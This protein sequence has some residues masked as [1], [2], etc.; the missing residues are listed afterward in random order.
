MQGLKRIIYILDRIA[1]FSRWTNV[2]GVAALFLMVSSTFIDVIMRYFFNSPIR[3]VGEGVGIMMIIAVFF[4]VAHTQNMRA[5]V[6]VDVITSLLAPKTLLMVEFITSIL[7]LVIFAV[8]IWQC[9]VEISWVLENNVIHTQSV[10]ISKAPFLIVI[11]LGCISL[12]LILLRDILAR[13]NEAMELGIGRR[14]WAVMFAVPILIMALGVLWMQPELFEI[15]LKNVGIIGVFVSIVFFLSGFPIAFAL[16][17]T[18]F[19]F[20]GHIRGVETAYDMLRTEFYRNTSNYTWSV[21]AFFVLMGFFCFFARF[22]EDLYRLAY[23]WLGHLRGGLAIATVGACGT[24]AA[25]VGDS[26]SCISTMS[27]IALPEMRKY[28]YKDTLSSGCI[29]C[30]A[31]LG[32]IIPPSVPLIVYGLITRESIGE[33]FIA[34]IIP[35]VLIVL[36]YWV[37]IYFWCRLNPLVGPKAGKSSWAERISSLKAGG[38]I[39]ILFVV[40]IGG[41]YRG[42]FTPTEGGAIG[43]MGAIFLGLIYRRFT[44]KNF[45]MALMESGK[46]ISMIFIILIGAVM[47]TRFLIWCNLSQTISDFFLGL[48]LSPFMLIVVIQIV[49]FI[50]GFLVDTLT[51]MLVA[52][53]IIH[54]IAVSLGFNPIWF[55]VVTVITINL[56]TITPPVAINLFLF[57]GLRSEIPMAS[58][59]RGALPFVVATALFIIILFIFPSIITWLPGLL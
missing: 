44:W 3:Y 12:W 4:A 7:G 23:R 57:K 54:P 39:A 16:I 37:I 35:G 51:L 32:P 18:S 36:S 20:V 5:Y 21:M 26:V 34:G 8:V 15:S 45:A 2:I 50:C 55:A 13:A 6:K 49:L 40:V 47:F 24:L 14:R 43:A 19:V 27:V 33:L 52:V 1:V 59:Y 28:G 17:L 25:I 11:I 48:G 46:V 42:V 31:T 53:P 22:G 38:P 56:G 58:I 9:I 41:I 30:G 10:P 29:T